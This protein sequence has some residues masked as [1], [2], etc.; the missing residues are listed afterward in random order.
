MLHEK[1]EAWRKTLLHI[2]FIYCTE[3][4]F[5]MI[6]TNDHKSVLTAF[7]KYIYLFYIKEKYVT[8]KKVIF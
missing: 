8:F 1:E 2:I 4:L 3:G 6:S 5:K 7:T